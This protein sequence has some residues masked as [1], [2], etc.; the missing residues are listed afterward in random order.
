MRRSARVSHFRLSILSILR[1]PLTG[2]SLAAVIDSWGLELERPHP[3]G[4]GP[5]PGL[6]VADCLGVASLV[7][8]GAVM[9]QVILH[10]GF[11]GSQDHPM[12]ASAGQLIDALSALR[13]PICCVRVFIW[14]LLTYG[15][16]FL[17]LL[18]SLIIKKEGYVALVHRAIHNLWLYLPTV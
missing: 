3:R 1:L 13:L 10:F 5:F 12:S 11:Q 14:C 17:R 6:A 4:E 2:V 7:A 15:V 18:P 16:P 9:L 8:D